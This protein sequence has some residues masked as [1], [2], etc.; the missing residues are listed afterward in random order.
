[1][2]HVSFPLPY[3]RSSNSCLLSSRSTLS[4][5]INLKCKKETFRLHSFVPSSR[6]S[7]SLHFNFNFHENVSRKNSLLPFEFESHESNCEIVLLKFKIKILLSKEKEKISAIQH[8]PMHTFVLWFILT[9]H[10]WIFFRSCEEHF[11]KTR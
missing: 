8:N 6:V 9:Y 7:H 11:L 2:F 1:M 5:G 4:Q 3:S 10:Q